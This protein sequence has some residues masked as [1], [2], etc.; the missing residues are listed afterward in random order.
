[1]AKKTALALPSHLEPQ[2]E[3]SAL[4]AATADAAAVEPAA[5]APS[6][7]LRYIV[8]SGDTLWSIAQR[9]YG[10]GTAWPRL[11][12]RHNMKVSIG[13]GGRWIA[14]PDLIWPGQW[15]HVPTSQDSGTMHFV[16]HV[17]YGDTLSG[18]AWRIYGDALLWHQIARDNAIQITNAAQIRPG[19][20][21]VIYPQSP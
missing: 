17:T 7:G 3:W 11:M 10:E 4:I 18:I 21:L 16:Y 9:F 2:I 8:R 19:Q 14:N 12:E 13:Q 1:M 6:D 5:R 15:L 20:V